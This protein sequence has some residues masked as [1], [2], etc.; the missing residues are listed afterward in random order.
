MKILIVGSNPSRKSADLTPFHPSTKSRQVLD[1]WF[2]GV[3]GEF[4]YINVVDQPTVDNKPL[5]MSDIKLVIP[6]LDHKIK[7][8]KADRII[9]VGK[10]AT[11]ALSM[12]EYDFL[13]APHP[14]GLNRKLN[15][16]TYV[17]NMKDTLRRYCETK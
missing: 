8:H 16:E 11:K 4:T 12:T 3:E 2:D 7:S 15:D 1:Q 9:T 6:A 5:K 17:K 13:E 10:T 14:S